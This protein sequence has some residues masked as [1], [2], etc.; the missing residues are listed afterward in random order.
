MRLAFCYFLRETLNQKAIGLLK[1][2][3]A[4]GSFSDQVPL[5]DEDLLFYQL[6]ETLLEKERFVPF[7]DHTT[8][9]MN[10][11]FTRSTIFQERLE[12]F[13]SLLETPPTRFDFTSRPH[14]SKTKTKLFVD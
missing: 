9:K 7:I 10:L 2:R 12:E 4:T 11:F 3:L 1:F 13:R 5:L 6:N 14:K 8:R